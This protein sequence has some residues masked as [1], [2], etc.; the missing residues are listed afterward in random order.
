MTIVKLHK[1]D[2]PIHRNVDKDVEDEG[3][4]PFSPP[5]AYSPPAVPEVSYEDMHPVLQSLR[6][7]HEAFVEHL[8]AFE[9]ALVTMR[10]KGIDRSATPALRAFF[11]VVDDE[12]IPHNRREERL[13]FPLLAKRLIEKGEH[14]KGRTPT[15]ALDVLEADHVE[16]VKLSAAVLGFFALGSRLPD[17]KSMLL[18]FDTALQQAQSLVEVLRLHIFREDNVVFPLAH[19]HLTK[20]ELDAMRE[21]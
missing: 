16:I 10:E 7:E 6:D 12:V 14:S 3:M 17:E 19:E 18:T 11:E 2:D 1:K 13:L 5:G 4:S 15:T 9:E 8:R 20:E 21:E